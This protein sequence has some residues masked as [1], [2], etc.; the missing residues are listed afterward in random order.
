MT[1]GGQLLGVFTPLV[2]LLSAG[3]MTRI[4]KRSFAALRAPGLASLREAV[5]AGGAARVRDALPAASAHGR[6][7]RVLT[8]WP[9]GNWLRRVEGRG[10][11][12]LRIHLC[13]GLRGVLLP[14]LP[15][16]DIGLRHL[17]SGDR[18]IALSMV[19]GGAHLGNQG[20]AITGAVMAGSFGLLSAFA[21]WRTG[22]IWLSIGM[23]ASWD[24]GETCFFGTPDSGIVAQGH[25]LNSAFH[26]PTWLTGGTV[27]PEGS[28]LV[29]GVLVVWA[30]TIH[31]WFPAG[32]AAAQR[33]KRSE[34]S[35]WRNAKHQRGVAVIDTTNAL[36]G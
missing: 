33:G 18:P 6:R 29:F 13:R 7:R 16:V 11:V 31:F 19:F 27:G 14:R 3:I 4:E 12:R 22:N 21:L 9:S 25:I 30:L 35:E 36:S 5:L 10:A 28:V 32:A 15:A 23:H 20:E 26:G 8:G 1:P 24:W 34:S 2:V 17:A